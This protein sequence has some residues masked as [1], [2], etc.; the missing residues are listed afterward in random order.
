MFSL[1]EESKQFSEDDSCPNIIQLVPV[2]LADAVLYHV[3]NSP[4][5]G[6]S[7]R[8]VASDKMRD[9]ITGQQ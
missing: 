7:G 5:V 1:I 8:N 2:F 3:Y 4:Q 9:H 6:H